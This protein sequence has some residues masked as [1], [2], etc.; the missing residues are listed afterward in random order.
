MRPSGVVVG[1]VGPKDSLQVAAAEYQYPVQ[2]FRPDRADPPL[3]ERIRSGR[4]DR[5]LDDLHA[6]GTEH[7]VE[8]T[9]ELAVPVADQEP[10]PP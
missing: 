9:G 4:S 2:T 3:R 1:G 6:L 10:D 7:L 8:R 5:A